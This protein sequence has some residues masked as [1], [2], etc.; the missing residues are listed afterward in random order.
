MLDFE[1]SHCV[2][3]DYVK[4]I[5]RVI[6]N[7]KVNS[8]LFRLFRIVDTLKDSCK[9]GNEGTSNCNITYTS[10]FTNNNLNNNLN[11]QIT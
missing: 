3:C 5:V 10:L 6:L 1:R 8:T 11:K 2:T 7:H 9:E 4:M